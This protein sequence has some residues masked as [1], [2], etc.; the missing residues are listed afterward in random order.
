MNKRSFIKLSIATFASPVVM[1]MLAWAGQ[2]GL[3]NWAGNIE[4]STDRVQTS[5]SLEQVQDYRQDAK[6]AES[7]R[8]AALLQ[9]HCR[10]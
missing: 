8:H 1:R 2:E 10:Q 5:T 4:Y 9:Q 6:Q 3:R 7:A